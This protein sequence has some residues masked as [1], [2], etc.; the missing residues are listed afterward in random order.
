MKPWTWKD[1]VILGF[2]AFLCLLVFIK[3]QDEKYLAP[4]REM[5]QNDK[6]NQT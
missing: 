5:Q 1:G 2:P 4:V 3:K 6:E